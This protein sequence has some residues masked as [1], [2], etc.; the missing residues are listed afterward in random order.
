MTC[1]MG[2]KGDWWELYDS[3]GSLIKLCLKSK[4]E[5]I[6]AFYHFVDYVNQTFSVEPTMENYEQYPGRV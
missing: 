1:Y 3:S 2:E 6:D 5:Y 4:Y